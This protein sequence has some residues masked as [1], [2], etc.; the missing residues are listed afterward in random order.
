[1]TPSILI[2]GKLSQETRKWL[3]NQDVKFTEH[4]DGQWLNE[5]FDAYLFLT[6]TDIRHY[7]EAGNMPM[8]GSLVLTSGE[9]SALEA[10]KAF[11]NEVRIINGDDE[12]TFVQYS[13]LHFIGALRDDAREPDLRYENLQ[14]E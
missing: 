3:V 12:L 2:G 7:K 5:G 11:P 10:Y 13:Y 14:W 9:H 6:S 8:P 1:M 4:V